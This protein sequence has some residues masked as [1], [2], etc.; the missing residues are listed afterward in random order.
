MLLNEFFKRSLTE[1][2]NLAIG[3]DQAQSIDLKVH[4]RAFIV[5]ILTKLL[6]GI[7]DGFAAVNQKPLWNPAL[8]QKGEFL[9][10]SSLHFF[11][12]KIP[13][14]QFE[15]VKPKVGDIDT[16]V[17]KLMEKE[18]EGWLNSVKGKL[19]GGGKLIGFERGNEQY[20]SLW[21]LQD[22]PIKIQIDLEFVAFDKEEP[23]AWSKFSHSSDWEDIQ[24]GVKGV[25]HKW[26]IQSFTDLTTRDFLLRKLVGRGKARVEQDVPAND[27]LLSFAVSS[28]EGGGLRPKYEPVTDEAGQPLI[29]DGLPVMRALPPAGYEQDIGKIFALIFGDRI[30]PKK[31]KQLSTKF[32]SFTG[33]LDVMTQVLSPEEQQQVVQAFIHKLYDK[34]AQGLYK[35]D[36]ERDAEE[37]DAAMAKMLEVLKIAP[38]PEL[39]QMKQSYQANYRMTTNESLREA[40]EPAPVKAQL[41]KG[42]PHLHDLKAPDFLDLL[43]EIHDGNGNF[44][45]QNVPLNVK[46]DGFGGRFGKDANGKPFMG[47]SRTEP[48]YEAS[49]V[50]YHQQKGTTDPEILG[51]AQMFDDLFKEMMNAIK[52]VDGKLGPDFLINKQVTCEVLF[53]PFATQTDE[54]RLKF[55]GIEYDQLPQGVQLALVPFHAVEADSGEPVEDPEFIDSLL[56][57]GNQGSVM[58]INNRLAQKEG[59]DVTEIINVLDNIEELKQIVS[60]TA[61]KRD[62]AS[63][64]LKKEV[65]EKLQPIKDQ[66]EQAIIKDPNIIGKDMLGKDY[67]GIVI[68]SRLGPIK[69]TSQEQRD[70]ISAK[71]DA[72]KNARTERPRDNQNKT[73]VVAIGSFVG[74]KGHQEL[75]Q[76]TQQEAQTLGGDP[77]LFIG[78]AEGK[79][80]PIPVPDKLK[81]W[82]MLYPQFA[83]NISAVTHEGGSI[84]QKI[85]HELINPLPGKPPRYD[86]IVIMV[87][88]DRKDL[89]LGKA[90]MKAV[91]KFPGYEHVKVDLKVTPRGQGV[92]GTALRNILKTG[93]PNQQYTFWND[94]FNGGKFGSQQLTPEWIKHLMDVTKKGMG[95]TTPSVTAPIKKQEQPTM[96]K[97]QQP[98]QQQQP[99]QEPLAESIR[100]EIM[101]TRAEIAWQK[102]LSEARMSA[103]VKLQ[104]AFDRERS[105]SDASRQRADAAKAAFEKEWKAKQEKE[106]QG[107]AEDL[108]TGHV[109]MLLH[110]ALQAR[111]EGKPLQSVMRKEEIALLSMLQGSGKLQGMVKNKSV[112]EAPIEMDPAEPMNPTIYGHQGVNSAE[113]KTRMMRA[114]GQLADL[115]KRAQNASPIEWEIITRNF[116]E[117]SMNIEQ[118]RHALEELAKVRKRG[119]IRS[120]GIDKNI[121]EQGVAEGLLDPSKRTQLIRFLAKKMDWEVN[122]LELATDHELIKWYKKV[123]AG[124]DPM[125]EDSVNELVGYKSDK[126]YLAVGTHKRYDVYVGKKKFNNLYFIAI[127]ENPRTLDAKFKAKGNTPQEAVNNLKLEIDKEIDVAT[128][129]SGAAILDF[130]VDFVKEIL[131]MSIDTFYA[132]IISGPKL[133]IAGREMMEYPDIMKSEGF[134]PSTIRTY[135]G[136][137]GT[138]KLPGVPLSAG[139]AAAASLIANGRYVLGAETTD[140]D[141]NRVFNLEFDSV[142]QASNDKMRLRAPAV[143]VG[144]NRSQGVAEA[145]KIKGADGKACWKGYKYAGTKNGKDKCVPVS[146]DAEQLMAGFIKLLESK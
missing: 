112:G 135:K 127:A 115:A 51:R 25:F 92:S 62:R 3:Q 144:T 85:K 58:F 137:E 32:W 46:V 77:Y 82:H 49:F 55:V 18:L 29:V 14:E 103:A 15:K 50:K 111:R 93:N 100:R 143:T 129:V 72:K 128:K 57:V 142:V 16:Q 136:G 69:I 126:N 86:N 124:Q 68:N 38:P 80:D 12:T 74:H 109:Q 63:L 67:E 48:R 21:E 41:R 59:L 42:M 52:L 54:G 81:T 1:G 106:K 88:E 118:I 97:P 133:V 22:P 4:N 60:D 116:K 94:T 105:K 65:E 104:R 110:K 123:Q 9:S 31:A 11:N 141:G 70:V 113:L 34:G 53:L 40:E 119:G 6:Y 90:L 78:N 96:A 83:K 146:E 125:K 39:A 66:L 13:D 98:V 140:K 7:N 47:T 132:K 130:N 28:K 138:S 44:K 76:Y 87:G 79:D 23:T 45:L 102:E 33:L 91:N 131:E 8:L 122:Y 145:G 24:A 43:D 99:E 10:G 5:P 84:M 95:I 89:P 19:I 61:G 56:E 36:P 101:I 120:R 134:K 75:W 20:S 27:N 2:G 64:Q 37:K 117:L 139:A 26:L 107:V 108:E 17:D 73:A 30:D 35:N 121:G 114:Q 71:L